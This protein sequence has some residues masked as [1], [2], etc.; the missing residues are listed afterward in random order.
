MASVP[1]FR[2]VRLAMIGTVVMLVA[3][4]LHLES[5]G[6]NPV[7]LIQPGADGPSA[8]V[9]EQDFPDLEIPDGLGHDGQ[10]FYAIARSPMHFD[11]VSNHLDRPRYRLQR[12]LFP[13]LAWALHPTG[14]G[15]GLVAALAAVGVAATFL[16]GLGAGAL[17]IQLGGGVWPAVLMP[18]LPGTF[19]ALRLT[20]AADTL[21]LGLV[22]VAL[23]AAERGRTTFAVLAAVLAV[24]SKESVLVILIG[25]AVFRRT[26]SAVVAALA[27]IGAAALW[28]LFL[29]LVVE[30]DSAQVL[31]FTWPFGGVVASAGDWASGTDWIAG[32]TVLITFVFAGLAL[33]R[34]GIRHPMFGALVTV[35]IFSIF[36]GQDVL[37]PNFNGPRT[38]GPVL[39]LAIIMLGTPGSPVTE[40]LAEASNE[41]RD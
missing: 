13:L 7:G 23:F 9:F 40:P 17:S 4:A 19:A 10:Q 1:W 36:L 3:V 38:I 27:A 6:G 31:E 37:G 33:W 26:R 41:R 5:K 12:P 8:D 34:R 20:L 2:L 28:W 22:L 21:A 35:T 16:L 14:G 18:L 30:A 11:E 29:R 32:V 25:H 15:Y 24:L 39:V